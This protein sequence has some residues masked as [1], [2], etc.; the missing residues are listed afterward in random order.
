MVDIAIMSY[1][2]YL[3]TLHWQG[4]KLIMANAQKG[5]CAFC[6]TNKN[7]NV[8]HLHYKT[9]G[10]ESTKDLK[11]LCKDCHTLWHAKLGKKYITDEI[12][13]NVRKLLKSGISRKKAILF[14]AQG[15][16]YTKHVLAEGLEK[17][18]QSVSRSSQHHRPH[19]K[20]CGHNGVTLAKTET[21][22]C[23]P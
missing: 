13:G 6:G 23:A 18:G 14:G 2:Q 7:I 22:A 9:I 10:N 3:K 16:K 5:K 19:H 1:K 8:H 21:P 15:T 11:R 4:T 17:N 20:V 12:V